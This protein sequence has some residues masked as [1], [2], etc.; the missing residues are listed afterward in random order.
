MIE[1]SKPGGG[2]AAIKI[3]ADFGECGC[4]VFILNC[5]MPHPETE[6]IL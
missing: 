5:R 4:S 1:L 6:R 2:Y 3:Q